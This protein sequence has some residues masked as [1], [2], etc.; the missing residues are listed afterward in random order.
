MA[1]QCFIAARLF[2][3][4]TCCAPCAAE[5]FCPQ[6]EGSQ[7]SVLLEHVSQADWVL[8]ISFIWVLLISFIPH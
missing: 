2:F 7:L 1:M 8:L 5:A 6:V 3:I 4:L